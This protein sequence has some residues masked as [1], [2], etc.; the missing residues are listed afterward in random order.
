M[1][2]LGNR[3]K[4]ESIGLFRY[5]DILVMKS[6]IMDYGDGMKNS[7]NK[8]LRLDDIKHE[9][10][11]ITD[12]LVSGLPVEKIY[13]F[14]SYAYGNAGKKSDIDMYVLISDDSKY[15]R[16]EAMQEAYSCLS[17]SKY[18]IATDVLV[19]KLS[20]FELK[21]NSHRL[22]RDVSSRGIQIYGRPQ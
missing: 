3:V 12:A 7:D 9:L 16:I 14:G 19:E 21:A 17:K 2:P 20:E 18:S 22:Q 5:N 10:S 13:H 15:G 1:H 4:R 6:A 11:I 8:Y